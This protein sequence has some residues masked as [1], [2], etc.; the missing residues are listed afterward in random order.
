[1]ILIVLMVFSTSIKLGGKPIVA[2][3]VVE[4]EL[5]IAFF[6]Y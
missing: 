3:I 4:R 5:M 1:M 2:A 6:C